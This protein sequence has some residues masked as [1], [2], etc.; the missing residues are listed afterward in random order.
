MTAAKPEEQR[1]LEG[2]ADHRPPRTAVLVGGRINPDE[3]DSV[4]PPAGLSPVEA[5]AWRDLI[6]PLVAGGMLDRVDLTIVELAAQALARIRQARAA[7]RAEHAALM[8]CLE[9]RR[10]DP[11]FR[12][13]KTHPGRCLWCEASDGELGRVASGG[14]LLAPPGTNSQGRVAHPAI[15]IEKG[16]MTEFRL[17]AGILGIGP[18]SRVK[19]AGDAGAG[20]LRTPHE[21]GMAGELDRQLPP[22]SRLRIVGDDGDPD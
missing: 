8:H 7:M 6:A 17:L 15:A 2:Y 18:G 9:A 12:Q 14:G 1:R 20:S 5:K 10:P 16:A 22:R 21:G 19:L 13:T 11:E 3:L 4:R